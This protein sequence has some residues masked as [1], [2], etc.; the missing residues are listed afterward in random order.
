MFSAKSLLRNSLHS[1]GVG[2]KHVT[3]YSHS[4]YLIKD[5]ITFRGVGV[6]R[7][8]E[9]LTLGDIEQH[10]AAIGASA[11]RAQAGS[12]A[13]AATRSIYCRTVRP[14]GRRPAQCSEARP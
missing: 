7:Y 13:I 4:L 1:L 2:S 10:L 3:E 12:R 11:A 6:G 5:T 14:D 9:A 8:L